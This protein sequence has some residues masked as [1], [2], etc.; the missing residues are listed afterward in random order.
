[1]LAYQIPVEV[2]RLDGELGQGIELIA[3]WQILADG[4]NRQLLS[5]RSNVSQS[6]RGSSYEDLVAAQSRAVADL[7]REIAEALKNI[8]RNTRAR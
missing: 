4:G 5:K 1:M 8:T 6:V 3:Q 7:A 2:I